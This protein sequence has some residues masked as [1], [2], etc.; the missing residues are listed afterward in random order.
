MRRTNR[1]I[2]KMLNGYDASNTS[3]EEV[4]RLLDQKLIES[5]AHVGISS[6]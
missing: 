6:R 5:S 2:Y 3:P 4:E 1:Y